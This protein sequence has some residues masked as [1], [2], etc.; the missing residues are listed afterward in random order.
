MNNIVHLAS[1]KTGVPSEWSLK[2]CRHEYGL[3]VIQA[4]E[5]LDVSATTYERMEQGRIQP[6]TQA[7]AETRFDIFIDNFGISGSQNFVL[8]VYPLR[9]A[10]E[11]LGLSA[12]DCA[13]QFGY[14]LAS[15]R[16]FEA[17]ARKLAPGDLAELEQILRKHVADGCA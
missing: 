6:P 11:I 8:G 15:W 5:A 10:R 13:R 3:S 17:N 14:S 12:E 16:K 4:A 7:M 9:R 1:L 2:T